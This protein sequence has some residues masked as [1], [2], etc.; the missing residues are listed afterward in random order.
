[1]SIIH[2]KLIIWL[3]VLFLV[4]PP[5]FCQ[6][7]E[8]KEYSRAIGFSVGALSGTGI[9]Y[10]KWYEKIGY[11]V[12]VGVTYSND[13]WGAFFSGNKLDYWSSIE[14]YYSLFAS[15][16]TRWLFGQLY[17]FV[18]LHH[19]G[20]ITTTAYDGGAYY[21]RFR[22][23]GGFGVELCL[24]HHISLVF[25]LGYGAMYGG[26]LFEDPNTFAIRLVPQGT[27]QYRF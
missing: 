3:F 21:P 13:E 20:Y 9:S 4:T 14:G 19:S 10:R 23:G 15:D 18:A 6:E 1:M 26:T 7:T 24:F 22:G 5:I 12:V 27:F 17:L 16:F 8:T 25:E 2:K 11:Q